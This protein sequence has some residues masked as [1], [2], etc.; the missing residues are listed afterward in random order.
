M[1]GSHGADCVV[2]LHGADCMVRITSWDRFVRNV[3]LVALYN[4]I[5]RLHRAIALCGCILSA[6]LTENRADRGTSLVEIEVIEE[7]MDRDSTHNYWV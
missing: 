4:S 1:V 5:V 2:R 6:V 7:S 3:S